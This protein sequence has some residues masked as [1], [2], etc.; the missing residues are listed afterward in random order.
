ML[1]DQSKDIDIVSSLLRVQYNS[2]S[3]YMYNGKKGMKWIYG[4]S[5]EFFASCQ[6]VIIELNI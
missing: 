3:V 6:T 5:I 2:G 1:L 4:G